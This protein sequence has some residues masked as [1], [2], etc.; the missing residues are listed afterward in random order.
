MVS[1]ANHPERGS[2]ATESKDTSLCGVYIFFN[3]KTAVFIRELP[4]TLSVDSKSI[5][6][7]KAENLLMLS[8]SVNYF[9]QSHVIV[10]TKP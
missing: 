1:E 5:K 6:A 4:I 3:V 9:I 10:R 7:A 8:R 2:K